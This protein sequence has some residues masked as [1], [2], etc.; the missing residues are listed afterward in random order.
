M[1]RWERGVKQWREKGQK[2]CD[3]VQRLPEE[4]VL[5]HVFKESPPATI[6]SRVGHKNT[7][8]SFISSLPCH[9]LLCSSS[10]KPVLHL[11]SSHNIIFLRQVNGPHLVNLIFILQ[12]LV[13]QNLLLLGLHHGAMEGNV[14]KPLDI[15]ISN[16]KCFANI[17]LILNYIA[18]PWNLILEFGRGT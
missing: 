1:K 4:L 11:S 17:S 5:I 6:L 7:S 12:H 15:L 2:W 14:N 3:Y 18:K 9:L 13:C 8:P 10:V 16:L